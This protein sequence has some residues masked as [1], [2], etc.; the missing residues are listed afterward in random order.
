MPGGIGRIR[1]EE[2]QGRVRAGLLLLVLLMEEGGRWGLLE[3][4][5]VGSWRGGL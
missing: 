3:G 5:G 1:E 4:A 2:R